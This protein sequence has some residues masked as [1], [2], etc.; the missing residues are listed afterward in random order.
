MANDLFPKHD[1]NENQAVRP[2]SQDEMEAVTG[3]SLRVPPFHG[4]PVGTPIS[5]NPVLPV[6]PVP[7][8]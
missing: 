6:I 7:T 8:V 2:L 5:P 3:G 4:G 1:D